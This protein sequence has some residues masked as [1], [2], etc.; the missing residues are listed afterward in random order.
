MQRERGAAISCDMRTLG[1]VPAVLL[2]RLLRAS[3]GMTTLREW[4]N[5]L[6]NV[7]PARPIGSPLVGLKQ[8]IALLQVSGGDPSK[9]QG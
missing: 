5:S 4:R 9:H 7:I 3:A 6:R 2:A 1:W 8:R